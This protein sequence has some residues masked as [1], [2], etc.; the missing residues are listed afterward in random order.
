VRD[1]SSDVCSSVLWRALGDYT[2]PSTQSISQ[3]SEALFNL[4]S[5]DQLSALRVLGRE[6][7]DGHSTLKIDLF[8]PTRNHLA[9]LWVDDSLGQIMRRINYRAGDLPAMEYRLNTFEPNVDFPQ[10][11]FDLQLP[12]RGGFALDF[13]GAPL[14]SDAAPEI[15]PAHPPL[16]PLALPADFDFSHSPL[17]FQYSGSYLGFSPEAQYQVFAGQY[18]IGQAYFGDP[19]KMICA[20]S[21]DGYWIAYVSQPSQSHD[22]SSMLHWFDLSDPAVRFFTLHDQTGITE[23]AFSPDTRR[24]AF[25][26]RPNPLAPGTLSTVSLPY[27]NVRPIYTTG[28]L[29]SLVWSPDGKSLAFI[30]RADP[31]GYQENILVISSDDGSVSYNAPLDVLNKPVKDWPMTA[32]GVNFPIEMGGMDA[33]AASPEP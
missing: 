33:C 24:L 13:R 16:T 8:D 15:A 14:D 28:D 23:L 5:F 31:S 6:D 26:S 20:R 4:S 17:T 27:Q 1:W 11:L 3:F 22:L 25:F 32:W 19:W 21:H 18:F 29:K 9:R 30:N 7:L 12:W 10:N 2:S